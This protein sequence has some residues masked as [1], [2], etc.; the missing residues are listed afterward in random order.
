MR[1]RHVVVVLTLLCGALAGCGSSGTHPATRA[2]ASVPAYLAAGNAICARQ[3]AQ[4][5]ELAQPHTPEQAI[6]YLPRAVAIMHSE[7]ADL[8]ALHVPAGGAGVAQLDAALA[9]TRELAGTLARFLGQLRS[10]MIDLTAFGAVQR[11]GISLHEQ[12]DRQFR[13]AGL[14][15]C[16]S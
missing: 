13:L 3:L 9:S 11:R 12:L 15:R 8:A 6:G 10:G 7:S 14:T 2:T 5:N 4:L 1:H 16:A